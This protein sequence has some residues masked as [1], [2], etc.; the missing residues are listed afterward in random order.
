MTARAVLHWSH[1]VRPAN[2]ITLTSIKVSCEAGSLF[3]VANCGSR[4]WWNVKR[5]RGDSKSSSSN[6]NAD[7]SFLLIARIHSRE[8]RVSDWVSQESREKF[9]RSNHSLW[10]NKQ[11]AQFCALSMPST[12]S[13]ACLS[14]AMLLA[15]QPASLPARLSLCLRCNALSRAFSSRKF[16][17]SH[18]HTRCWEV[19]NKL[20]TSRKYLDFVCMKKGTFA[21]RACC[22]LRRQNS[23]IAHST[24]ESLFAINKKQIRVKVTTEIRVG[25]RVREWF[26]DKQFEFR[27][28]ER[29]NWAK[30]VTCRAWKHSP[31]PNYAQVYIE[32]NNNNYQA[33]IV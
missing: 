19:N 20:P 5:L 11:R 6:D 15:S 8:S 7:G 14:Y 10:G 31:T 26:C 4:E 22:N 27:K 16:A 24:R 2:R 23:L 3:A 12:C 17:S 29:E 18:K 32:F 13:L 25:C 30:G 33:I 1:L 21:E 9:A 28:T